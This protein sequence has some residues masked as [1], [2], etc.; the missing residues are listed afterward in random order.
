MNASVDIIVSSS[1]NVYQV[2]IDAVGKDGDT[3]YVYRKTSGEGTDMQFE[4]VTVTT[5]DSN[6]YY[7]EISSADLAAGDVIR[8]NSDLSEGI[9]TVSDKEKESNSGGLL[10]SLFG[11]SNGGGRGDMPQGGPQGSGN[12]RSNSNSNSSGGD[13]PSPPSGDMG[14]DQNG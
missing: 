12:N 7:V 8:S 14:G 13:M 4:K 2:P 9:E 11:G 6:D 3:N 5:G 1:E 10:S